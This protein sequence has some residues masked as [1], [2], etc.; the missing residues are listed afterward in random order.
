MAPSG[1]VGTLDGFEE[2]DDEPESENNE[3]VTDNQNATLD[4]V[5]DS[6]AQS[7]R[8][9]Q[10]DS[11]RGDWKG[12]GKNMQNLSEAIKELEKFRSDRE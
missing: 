11:A 3:S 9:A 1:P 5:I 2:S 7:Y 8:S 6:I 4:S 10:S 12:F